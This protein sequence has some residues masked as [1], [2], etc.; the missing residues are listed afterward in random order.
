MTSNDFLF[1][2][3]LLAFSALA[4]CNNSSGS[5]AATSGSDMEPVKSSA[6][7]E[8]KSLFDGKSLNGWHAFNKPGEINNWTVEDGA[9]V[10]LGAAK[11]DSGGDIVTD[12]E[13]ENFELSWEWKIE[14]GG[15]SGLMYHVIEDPKYKAPYETGPEYQMYDDKPESSPLQ[16]TGADYAMYPAN[17]KKQAKPAGE[18]NTSRIIFDNGQVE[19]WLN[20]EKIV[21]FQAWN[22]DW[23]AR[24][25]EG[26]WNNYP[27]Y[28]LA[29][30][31]K[32]ALQDHG[33]KTWFRNITIKEL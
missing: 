19:H 3:A 24:K 7:T 13:Y 18:W 27:D 32:I 31:G 4:S 20:G 14:K 22:D 25:K 26:K 11:G 16:R 28:G 12:A 15:N 30:K 23:Y 2:T 6:E 17:D 10:C 33:K 21:S 5:D 29:K 9:M 8:A 1:S